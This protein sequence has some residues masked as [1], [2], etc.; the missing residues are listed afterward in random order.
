MLTLGVVPE[1]MGLGTIIPITKNKRISYKDSHNC[2]PITLSSSL[3]KLFDNITLP[4]NNS[5][6][7]TCDLEFGFKHK[8]STVQCSFALKEIVQYQNNNNSNVYCLLLDAT[9]AFD[10]VHYIKLYN[11]LNRRGMCSLTVRFFIRLYTQQ[12]VRVKW[13]NTFSPEFCVKKV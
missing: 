12:K 9:Q 3:G 11:T 6:L 2:K 13:E 5:V 7:N 10:L 8:H 4:I 1:D